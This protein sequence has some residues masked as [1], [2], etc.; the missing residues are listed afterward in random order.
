MA[1]GGSFTSRRDREKEYFVVPQNRQRS[2]HADPGGWKLV[3]GYDERGGSTVQTFNSK[4]DAEARGKELARK[5]DTVLTSYDAAKKS[6]RTFD[7]R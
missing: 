7:Y 5:N 2:A 4:R 6:S 3:K 1:L